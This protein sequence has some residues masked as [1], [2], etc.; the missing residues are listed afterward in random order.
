MDENDTN[1]IST[2]PLTQADVDLLFFEAQTTEKSN[3]EYARRLYERN[4]PGAARSIINLALASSN[5]AI[6]LKAAMYVTDRAL[7]RIPDAKTDKFDED[8][9][10]AKLAA[11]C[12]GSMPREDYDKL[13]ETVKNRQP[14]G[15]E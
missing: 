9:P 11:E 5:D 15:D 3:P 13:K 1:A 14:E 8:D 7:G 4:V 10:Y 2:A 6:R 12:I